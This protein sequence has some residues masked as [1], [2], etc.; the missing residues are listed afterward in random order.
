M[1]NSDDTFVQVEE[2][3]FR[4]ALAELVPSVSPGELERYK[5]V[6]KKFEVDDKA[7]KKGKGKA[8]EYAP[9]SIDEVDYAGISDRR[10]RIGSASLSIDTGTREVDGGSGSSKGSGSGSRRGEHASEQKTVMSGHIHREFQGPFASAR[11]SSSTAAPIDADHTDGTRDGINL[12]DTKDTGKGVDEQIPENTI[13]TSG[14][15][16]AAATDVTEENDKPTNGK[17]VASS[18]DGLDETPVASHNTIN[19]PS[20]KGKGKAPAHKHGK[21][22]GKGRR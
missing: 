2:S 20:T 10:D 9:S 1:A 8:V 6:R 22:K 16:T 7:K 4:Q 11:S 18:S 3:D 17:E 5:E 12:S 15:D 19:V 21:K 14:E 13:P